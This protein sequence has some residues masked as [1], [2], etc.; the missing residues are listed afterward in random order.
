MTWRPVAVTMS[1]TSWLLTWLTYRLACKDEDEGTSKVRQEDGHDG[2][3]H[4]CSVPAV[5][6]AVE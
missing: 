1:L 6:C 3:P 2:E 4:D 5:V